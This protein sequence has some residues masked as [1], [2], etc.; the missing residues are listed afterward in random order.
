MS[1]EAKTVL[2]DTLIALG[3]LFFLVGL[4]LCFL[5]GGIVSWPLIKVQVLCGLLVSAGCC[6]FMM[7]HMSVSV[8][9]A[10]EFDS[11]SAAN[12]MTK[13]HGVRYGVVILAAVVC[14]LTGW[15]NMVSFALGLL[16]LKPAIY[17]QLLVHRIRWGAEPEDLENSE[18]EGS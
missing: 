6:G 2:E 3:I 10:V 14:Y 15:I 16:L 18:V 9:R 8:D 17:L 13:S 11:G 7:I 12:Y 1:K 4:V 5:W